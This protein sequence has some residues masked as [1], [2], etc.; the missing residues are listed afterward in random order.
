MCTIGATVAKDRAGN[1][2]AF[3][4]KTADCWAGCEFHHSIQ[5][6]ENGTRRIDFSVEPQFGVNSGLN[7]H[8]LGLVISY[9]DYRF[10]DPEIYTR[11]EHFRD[12]FVS[13]EKEPRTEMNQLVLSNCKTVPQAIEFIEGFVRRHPEMMG[14]NHLLADATGNLAI[15][16][17]CEGTTAVV[18][19]SQVGYT[20]RGNNSCLL[21]RDKQASISIIHDC[22][23]RQQQMEGFL[24]SQMAVLEDGDESRFVSSAKVLLGSHAGGPDQTGSICVHGLQVRGTRAPAIGPFGTKPFWTATAL[25]LD[26]QRRQ[27][28]F[29]VNNPCQGEWQSLDLT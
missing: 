4:L 20:G 24:K 10:R 26:L 27:M 3:L 5:A 25:V 6:S 16:E 21:I 22:L 18:D 23:S 1:V 13:S 9:S 2:R 12:V 17:Q 28:L 19:Y 8:G 14:G 29:S 11:D 15:V 7:E